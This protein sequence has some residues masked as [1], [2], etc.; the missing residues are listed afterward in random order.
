M[1][2]KSIQILVNEFPAWSDSAAWGV[3]PTTV[4][5]LGRAFCAGDAAGCKPA[6]HTGPKAY[7]PR[8]VILSREDGEGPLIARVRSSRL[9]VSSSFATATYSSYEGSFAIFA[10]QDDNARN[11]GL[12]PCVPS[13]FATRCIASTKRTAES[14]HGRRS[15]PPRRAVTPRWKFIDKNLN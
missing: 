6:G 14:V 5:R 13:G 2:S 10:A 3:A 4:H 1:A 9:R 7:V 11:I 12:W 15:N 8:V